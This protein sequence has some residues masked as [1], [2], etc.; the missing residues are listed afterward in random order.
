MSG[1]IDNVLIPRQRIAE[2][3]EQL[4]ADIARTLPR[5]TGDGEI[6]LVPILTGSIIFLA[7]LIRHLP[8]KLRIELVT[9]RSYP[10]TATRSQGPTITGELPGDL[11]GK[12][13]VIIDDVLDTGGTLRVIQREI[14]RLEPASLR[15]CVLLRKKIQAADRPACEFVG[16]EIPNRF[17]VGY[18][19]DYDDYY[20]NL[21]DIC[22][23]EEG[24]P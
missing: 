9:V 1:E 6:V 8:H 23:L 10:G 18:G 15:T 4:G 13:V 7:D 5:D 22:T 11:R 19:L 14:E 12:H 17:V 20:R 24:A 2:R 3:V 16:F 21:P